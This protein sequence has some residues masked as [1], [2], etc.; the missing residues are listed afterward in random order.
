MTHTS[1]A[2]F[3]LS[4]C[5]TFFSSSTSLFSRLM[6]R[7]SVSDLLCTQKCTYNL[8]IQG[9]WMWICLPV[10]LWQLDTEMRQL[11]PLKCS[12]VTCQTVTF[13]SVQCHSGL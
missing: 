6:L 8:T 13:R 2:C 12:D 7:C 11:N 10:S 4:S 9:L 3:S 1:T 5:W